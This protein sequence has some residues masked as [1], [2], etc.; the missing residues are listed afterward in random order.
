MKSLVKIKYGKG[1]CELLECKEPI[2]NN[3]EVIVKVEW[4]GICGTDINILRGTAEYVVPVI[5]G[6]EFAGTV[7]KV[8]N[9]VV[10]IHIGDKV[11]AETSIKTCGSC[12]NCTAGFYNVCPKRLGMG[13][14]ANGAF[15]EK[16]NVNYKLVHKIP[17]NLS[18][19]EASL[20][21]PSAVAHHAVVERGKI[22]KGDLVYVFGPGPIGIL[23]SQISL[24]LGARVV[25]IGLP[26]D[27]ERLKICKY[28]NCKTII[29]NS[30]QNINSLFTG[31]SPDAVF[32]CSGSN[33]AA[34][35]ALQ[36][37][38]PRGRYIQI[39]LF[40][41]DLSIPMNLVSTKEINI[42]GSYSAVSEDFES[43]LN[44]A[45]KNKL[46]LQCLIS[47][48]FPL[49]SWEEAFCIAQN[50]SSLKVLLYL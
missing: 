14:T 30:K 27:E 5:L 17:K 43:V 16:I 42:M 38:K 15:S 48:I 21:E 50:I 26:E 49:E 25:V 39:G 12:E 10:G 36:V 18:T 8:G 2:M 35:V 3:C 19:K 41:N 45:S 34:R 28:L 6:H 22:S 24:I 1:G 13:R 23:V 33:N 37:V 31:R 4:C 32:E 40:D 44:L 29:Y 7:V 46:N 20:C 9:K 47:N 11:V